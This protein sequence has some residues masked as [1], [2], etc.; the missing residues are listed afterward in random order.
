MFA[1][2]IRRKIGSSQAERDEL[3]F[4]SATFSLST[5]V[6]RP[7]DRRADDRIAPVLPLAKL[8]A[9][10]W[11]DLCRIRNISAGGLMAEAMG[12]APPGEAR[13]FIE[14]DSSRRVPGR[15][16]WVRDTLFGVKF[17]ETVDVRELLAGPRPRGGYAPRP[18]R[19]DVTCGA[20][21]KIGNLYH[22]VEV[23]DISQGGMR[24]ALGDWQCVGKP[25]VVTI[26][27]LRPVKGIVR[28]YR[29]GHAGIVFEKPLSFEELAEWLGKRVDVASLKTGAWD[30]GRR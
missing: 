23:N 6:P 8:V 9:E 17:D 30:R 10:D 13:I 28:W 22:K 4:E 1:A 16:V 21:V 27:S 3:A 20:T 29:Q 25:A 15:V 19:L 7:S 26:E 2:L 5:E 11:Q 24:V 18:P 14:F 12:A